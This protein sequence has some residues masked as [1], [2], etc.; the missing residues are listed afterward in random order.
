MLESYYDLNPSTNDSDDDYAEAFN[1]EESRAGQW[2][3]KFWDPFNSFST[4]KWSK[5]NRP[6]YNSNNCSYQSGQVFTGSYNNENFLVLRAQNNGNGKWKSGHVKSKSNYD[7]GN[8]RELRFRAKIKFNS[9]NSNGSWRPFYESTG[10]WPAF[11]TVNESVWPAEGEID[12]ME[13]YTYGSSGSDRYASNLFYGPTPL[14]QGGS[15]VLNMN[16]SVHYYSNDI[17]PSN[18]IIYEMRWIQWNNG[19]NVVQIYING[20]LKKTYRNN[21]VDNLDLRKFKDHNMILNLNVGSDGG[22]FNGFTPNIFGSTDMLV[23]WVS[24]QERTR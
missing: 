4:N 3:G 10:A 13:G 6:D 21:N 5:T 9:F 1:D 8:G 11:W 12:I 16:Q 18:W 23:D 14:S 22:I 24:V 15:S 17:N 20:S 19:G 2:V 7:P